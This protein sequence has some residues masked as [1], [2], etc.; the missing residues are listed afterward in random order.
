MAFSANLL[1]QSIVLSLIEHS[2]TPERW[3]QLKSLFEAALAQDPVQR[4]QFI[5]QCRDDELRA[6]LERLLLEHDHLSGFLAA[7][8][9]PLLPDETHTIGPDMLG[10]GQVLGARYQIVRMVGRGGMGEVY[11]A[12]DRELH[13]R[14]ALKTLRAGLPSTGRSLD[15]FKREI[16]LGRRIAHPNICRIFHLDRATLGDKGEVLFLTMEFLAGETLSQ[17]LKRNGPMD[18][19]AAEPIVEDILAGLA[20]CHRHGIVHRDFKS[21]NIMLVHE[22]DEKPR[23]VITD[24]GLA[25]SI[26]LGNPEN[27]ALTVEGGVMGTPEYMAPEQWE[28]KAA[29]EASDIYA[30]GVVLCEML[31]GRRP[32]RGAASLPADRLRLGRAWETVILR[33]IQTDPSHRF[34]SADEVAAALELALVSTTRATGKAGHAANRIRRNWQLILTAALA[35]LTIS[36]LWFFYHKTHSIPDLKHVAVLPFR[37]L[38]KNAADQVFCEG[39]A[40]TLTSK[41]SQLER[42]QKSFWVVPASDSRH[43][44]EPHDAYRKLDATLVVSGSLERLPSKTVLL[45]NVIDARTRRQL[46]SRDIET[47]ASDL[48]GLEDEAWQRV[49]DMLDLQLRP[50]EIRLVDA[51]KA[52]APGAYVSYAQGLGYLR[53]DG[54]ENINSAI[55]RFQEAIGRDPSYALPYSGLGSAYALKYEITKDPQWLELA[56]VNA[57]RA[58]ALAPDLA[59]GHFTLGEI[60]FSTGQD[61]EAQHELT[62]ALELDP[63][64]IEAHYYLGRLHERQ[65][66]LAEAAVD[67]QSAVARRPGYWRGHSE[68]ATFYYHHGRL[69]EAEHESLEALRLQPDDANSLNNLGAIYMATG[70]FQEAIRVFEDQVRVDPNDGDVYSNLGTC[71][72]LLQRY[73]EAVAPMEKAVALKPNSHDLWRNL[74]DAYQ[75][76]PGQKGKADGAYRR[77]LELGRRQLAINP[78][79]SETMASVALYDAHLNNRAE[80]IQLVE[81]SMKMAPA[82]NEI[83]F[84]AALVYEIL[85]EH[86]ASLQALRSAYE[87]GHPL[88]DIER[89]PELA[90]LRKDPRYQTWVQRVKTK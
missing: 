53:R 26:R 30:L 15:R 54:L 10:S 67:F 66:R 64:V 36:L 48:S 47:P 79:D 75:F 11:E 87:K 45:I 78:K 76:A 2:M 57:K 44:S 9:A 56:R 73:A 83:F 77:A 31:T 60:D 42:Y 25:H 50:E 81:R 49:A 62:R 32:A 52:H 27:A 38:G 29:T 3:E 63:D 5:S 24:F 20:A 90:A 86:S 7:P 40:E 82:N 37:Y 85:G 51:G 71:F 8:A 88:D 65:G 19:G 33:C 22:P 16:L 59:Q 43:V 13:C 12:E 18:I 4:A 35:V 34:G 55:S 46:A 17:R 89:E 72:L 69:P 14:I 68:L 74:G 61:D 6:E 1:T 70:R 23:A 21:S 39:L 84:T 41:L 28:G 80:A 58:I